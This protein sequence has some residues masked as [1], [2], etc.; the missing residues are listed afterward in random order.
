M[1]TNPLIP[2]E[3]RAFRPRDVP[4]NKFNPAMALPMLSEAFTFPS[5]LRSAE[6]S[7]SGTFHF[8]V[9][10]FVHFWRATLF[11]K[12]FFRAVNS[13]CSRRQWKS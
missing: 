8:C 6:R 7:E 2:L 5:T 4:P 13:S 10:F 11:L 1:Q 3:P 12:L 9:L